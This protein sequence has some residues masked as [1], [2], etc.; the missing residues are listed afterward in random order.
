[1]PSGLVCPRCLTPNASKV[2]KTWDVEDSVRRSRRCNACG[3]TFPTTESVGVKE[4]LVGKRNNRKM[5]VFRPEKVMEGLKRA[6]TKT[7]VKEEYIRELTDIICK[8]LYG[9]GRDEISSYDIGRMTLNVIL[10][11]LNPANQIA[12]LRFGDC[13]IFCV[14]GIVE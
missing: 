9:L 3:H 1:M 12:Y 7:K 14:N 6:F 13:K 11:D 5:E 4:L 8:N 10:K 2:E